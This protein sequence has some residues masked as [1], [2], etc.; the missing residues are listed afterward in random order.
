MI[1]IY[2]F[3]NCKF[4]A[5][6]SGQIPLDHNKIESKDGQK[7]Q[8]IFVILGTLLLRDQRGHGVLVIFASIFLPFDF[9]LM[10]V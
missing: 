4:F 6:G 10:D 7:S 8:N 9:H 1:L 3:C 2:Y 5:I